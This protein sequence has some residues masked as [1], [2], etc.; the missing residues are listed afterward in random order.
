VT[1]Q[2]QTPEP[3]SPAPVSPASLG[4]AERGGGPST[5]SFAKPSAPDPIAWP[6]PGADP[7]T[8]GGAAHAAADRPEIAVG[9][10]FAAGFVLA[11]ILRRIAR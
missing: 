1:D 9:G 5:E 3:D 6:P 4:P 8:D 2:P 7:S 10:A 11:M